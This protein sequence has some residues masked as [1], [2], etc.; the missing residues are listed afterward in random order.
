V[1]TR[2]SVAALLAILLVAGCQQLQQF[3]QPDAVIPPGVE[4][5]QTVAE[6]SQKMLASIAEN[7]RTLRR[8]LAPVRIIRIQLLRAGEEYEFKLLDGT[9]PQG[10]GASADGGPGWMVEAIG[11]FVGSDPQTGRIDSLGTH[12]F[13]LWA[14][15]GGE[16]WGF[17]PCWTRFRR[18]PKSLRVTARVFLKEAQ[19]RD[20]TARVAGRRWHD[21]LLV[22]RQLDLGDRNT[23]LLSCER[24][25]DP[26][27]AV[28]HP[29]RRTI[30]DDLSDPAD[31]AQGTGQC[32]LLF[33]GMGPPVA[34]VRCE[35]C[36]RDIGVTD[37]PVTPGG[38]P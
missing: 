10:A 2:H 21:P 18:H 24:E 1:I 34:R 11:T 17:I 8:Q 37:D 16:T 27:M 5:S 33:P 22:I 31:L 6:V 3:T 23:E 29:S 20:G 26:Q 28:D 14:D 19:R 30:D 12:G 36:R 25:V 4:S 35:L 38:C 9:N 32:T 7:E 15:Q 13:H